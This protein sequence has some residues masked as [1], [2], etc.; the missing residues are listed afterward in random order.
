MKPDHNRNPPKIEP[1]KTVQPDAP[2]QKQALQEVPPTNDLTE[3]SHATNWEKMAQ[4]ASQSLKSASQKE[5]FRAPSE[6]SATS[7]SP[8]TLNTV[9]RTAVRSPNVWAGLGATT[10]CIGSSWLGVAGQALATIWTLRN[11]LR[12]GQRA[13]SPNTKSHEIKAPSTDGYVGLFRDTL[14]CP[15]FNAIV[16]STIYI[17]SAIEAAI[18][19]HVVEPIFFVASALGHLAVAYLTN[20][21]YTGTRTDKVFPERAW[22]A[23]WN[24]LPKSLHNI[25]RNPAPWFATG[26]ILI[27]L[28][29]MESK[30]LSTDPL[31][32]TLLAIGVAVGATCVGKAVWSAFVRKEGEKP[33]GTA[34]YL[35]SATSTLLGISSLLRGSTIVGIANLFWSGSNLLVG[36][37]LNRER[38]IKS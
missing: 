1:G 10:I 13:N 2:L 17:G 6:T 5:A 34:S 24:N 25:F 23:I 27:V 19:G 16:G 8:I 30:M 35:T 15:G 3:M 37:L 22:D 26:N 14:R 38:A 4:A 28:S 29:N 31:A 33:S 21:G 12:T 7:L 9:L 11:E 32:G 36:R 18:R 20:L